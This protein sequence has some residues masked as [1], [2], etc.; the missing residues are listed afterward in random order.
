MKSDRFY[1]TQLQ[2]GLGLIEETKTLLDLWEP[3]M[4]STELFQAAL[5]SGNFPNVSARRLRNIVAE[6]FTPRY[7]VDGEYPANVLKQLHKRLPS[8][9]F[10]QLLFLFTARA[11]A[12]FAD[13]VKEV[14]WNK[15]AGGHESIENQDARQFVIEANQAGKTQKPWAESTI[16]KVSSYLTGCCVDFGLL[17]SARRNVRKICQYHADPLTI[18]F[19]AH[20]L[21]FSGLGDN[22]VL[23]HPDWGLFGL[24]KDDVRDELKR[25]SYRGYFI[26]QTAG[27]VV[28]ISWNYKNWKDFI[29]VITEG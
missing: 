13:F 25:L 6:C 23:A 11:N 28:H 22:A 24:Q 5:N 8:P 7:L 9:V 4:R 1:T 17:A 20:D 12:I 2:A 15:Y 29:N 27:D 16:K 10:S 18:A 26:V 14:F 3:G 21:H 19:I